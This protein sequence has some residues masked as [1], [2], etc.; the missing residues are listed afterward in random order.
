MAVKPFQELFVEP[1]LQG[2]ISQVSLDWA[3]I[4]ALEAVTRLLQTVEGI[5]LESMFHDDSM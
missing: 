3:L 5:S 2:T 1:H 4:V